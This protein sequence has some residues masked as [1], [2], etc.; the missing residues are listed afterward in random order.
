MWGISQTSE[1]THR[2][3]CRRHICSRL[4][5]RSVLMRVQHYVY[6]INP[7]GINHQGRDQ[8][9]LNMEMSVNREFILHLISMCTN[10]WIRY[11]GMYRINERVR[12][13]VKG[14]QY[15]LGAISYEPSE[16]NSLPPEQRRK[17]IYM[18][19]EHESRC[20]WVSEWV[21]EVLCGQAWWLILRIC[22]LHL[23]HPSAHTQQ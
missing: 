1:H 17:K 2:L 5:H 9:L 4:Y 14:L 11:V 18:V 6:L 23:T 20:E 21:S 13:Q 22:V 15:I 16:D 7:S 19:G 8:E 3:V 12:G 10:R